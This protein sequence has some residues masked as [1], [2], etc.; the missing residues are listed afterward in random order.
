MKSIVGVGLHEIVVRAKSFL[1]AALRD[2]V[3]TGR[4]LQNTGS[5]P[6]ASAWA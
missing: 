2:V 4:S 3:P 6:G 5:P 1:S